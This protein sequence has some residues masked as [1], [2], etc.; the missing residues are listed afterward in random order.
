MKER[1]L[2]AIGRPLDTNDIEP[3]RPPTARRRRAQDAASQ[4]AISGPCLAIE[5]L[6]V[7]RAIS[8]GPEQV[9]ALVARGSEYRVGDSPASIEWN[10]AAWH[11]GLPILIILAKPEAA[12]SSVK[13]LQTPWSDGNSCRTADKGPAHALPGGPG[14]ILSQVTR[15]DVDCAVVG[16]DTNF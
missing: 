12:R 8:I 3:A 9:Y 10:A 6:I 14:T 5:E 2:I 7:H 11:V 15:S 16:R 1:K 4:V 13:S